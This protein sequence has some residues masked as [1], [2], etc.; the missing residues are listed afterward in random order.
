MGRLGVG[1]GQLWSGIV[2][3]MLKEGETLRGGVCG[4]LDGGRRK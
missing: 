1:K 3:G 2:V 4:G